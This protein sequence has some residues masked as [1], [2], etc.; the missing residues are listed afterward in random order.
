MAL[1]A[2]TQPAIFTSGDSVPLAEVRPAPETIAAQYGLALD[3]SADELGA[4]TFILVSLGA[5]GDALLYRY[6]DST[7]TAT[8]VRVDARADL[9]LAWK[10]LR[11]GLDIT[12]ADTLW[13]NPATKH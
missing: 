1:D 4:F 9:R 12:P 2:Y 8:L 6:L 7:E 5:E 3:T 13:L 11:R 10:K